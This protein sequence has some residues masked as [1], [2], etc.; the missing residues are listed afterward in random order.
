M[1]SEFVRR[2]RTHLKT[3]LMVVKMV[4]VSVGKLLEHFAMVRYKDHQL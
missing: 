2:Q 4:A 1:N 3:E